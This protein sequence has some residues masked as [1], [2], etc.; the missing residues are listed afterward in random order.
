MIEENSTLC[1][2]MKSYKSKIES[3]VWLP[4]SKLGYLLML[5]ILSAATKAYNC[6]PSTKRKSPQLISPIFHL[7]ADSHAFIEYR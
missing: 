1:N 7:K 6:F 3:C 2:L 5:R 4:D